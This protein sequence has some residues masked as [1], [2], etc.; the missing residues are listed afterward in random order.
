[1]NIHPYLSFNGNCEEAFSF[2]AK[3]FGGTLGEL[4]RYGN[5]PMADEGGGALK[6]KIMH[7]SVVVHGQTLMGADMPPGQYEK[8]Q[9]FSISVHPKEVAEAERIFAE[10]SSGGTVQMPLEKTFWAARFG[11][12]V[13]RFGIPW[14]V[15]CEG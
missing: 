3:C 15:N 2:Y 13:D 6:D 4:F 1:M 11:A 8:P 10:L 7:G 14:T 5:S 9:G 12:C